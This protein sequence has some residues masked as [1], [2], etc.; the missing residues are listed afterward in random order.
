[1]FRKLT[2]ALIATAALGTVA[3]V[4]TS[5][6]AW[7]DRHQGWYGEGFHRGEGERHEFEYRGWRF[8]DHVRRE[9]QESREREHIRDSEYD[10]RR[11]V[12]YDGK[13]Y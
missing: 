4:P 11:G 10:L 13:R 9:F 7:E 2:S 12:R 8:E 3:L 1:M 5:A 6:S